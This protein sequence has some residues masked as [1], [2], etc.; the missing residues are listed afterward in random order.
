M[1][2]GLSS[3]G[4][5][6]GLTW[7]VALCVLL[8]IPLHARLRGTWNF[9]GKGGSFTPSSVIRSLFLA[10]AVLFL[11]G[12]AFAQ[13]RAVITIAPPDLPVYEQPTCPRSSDDSSICPPDG[14]LW[15]PGYWAWDSDYYWVP[16]TW[17]FAP[18]VGDFWTP[19]YWG[20][21]DGG[22]V[23]HQGYWGRS[24]GFYGGIDY[25]FGYSGR[26]YQGA[27]WDDGWLHY[28]SAVNHVNTSRVGFAYNTPVN[29]SANR[30][31]YNG[32]SGGINTHPTPEEEAADRDK[33]SGPTL[34]QDQ[35]AWFA[36]NDPQQRFSA[37]HGAPPITA[38][39]L[40]HLAIHPTELPP[41]ERFAIHTGNPKLD[42]E[43]QKQLD[44]LIARQY[45]ERKE[46]Q[47]KH[48]M[49]RENI[50]KERAAQTYNPWEMEH[51]IRRHLQ[52]SQELYHK[53]REE[54]RDLQQRQQRDL[55]GQPKAAS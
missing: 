3:N 43:Y 24:V 28:N 39:P 20:W 4:N 13:A 15:M 40:P 6:V 5:F 37:N 42:Q 23:F 48:D 30:I 19:G 35:H 34:Q 16:G 12:T 44:E 14:Y 41:I 36:H 1:N 2:S 46:L 52:E 49:D 31:S 18:E 45:Q 53:Q 32:G 54:M 9:M 51:V 8:P 27:R 26:G 33:R 17:V 50:N 7:L 25:G 21:S 22:Y 29:D 47:Q 10:A 11:S 55:G 38:T